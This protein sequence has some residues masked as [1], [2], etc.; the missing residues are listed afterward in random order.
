M[1]RARTR[2]SS[3]SSLRSPPRSPTSCLL[4]AKKLLLS[5]NSCGRRKTPCANYLARGITPDDGDG[6]DEHALARK[7]MKVQGIITAGVDSGVQEG[8]HSRSMMARA[9]GGPTCDLP[10]LGA[11][12][13]TWL[14]RLNPHHRPTMERAEH[15]NAPPPNLASWTRIAAHATCWGH[16]WPQRSHRAHSRPVL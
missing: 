1:T 9:L 5:A 13:H 10:S 7:L 2:P 4:S 11:V 16:T 6:D 15:V 3:A 12:D 8:L 14:W